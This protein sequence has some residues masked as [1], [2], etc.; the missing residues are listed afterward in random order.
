MDTP[1]LIEKELIEGLKFPSEEVL[2]EASAIEGRKEILKKAL[3]LGN[4][5]KFK[6]AIIFEDNESIKRVETTVWSIAEKNIGLKAGRTIPIHRIHKI[7][8]V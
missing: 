1:L 8:F 2:T 3:S 6:V 4:L 5:N 7:E